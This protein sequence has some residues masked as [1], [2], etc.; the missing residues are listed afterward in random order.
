MEEVI[1]PDRLDGYQLKFKV[2]SPLKHIR[3][4]LDSDHKAYLP[5]ITHP[6][7]K[8]LDI[9]SIGFMNSGATRDV[10]EAINN[11]KNIDHLLI[12]LTNKELE[13]LA[14]EGPFDC[15]E[16]N[17]KGEGEKLAV[18]DLEKLYL[19][20]LTVHIRKYEELEV[21]INHFSTSPSPFTGLKSFHLVR[22]RVDYKSKKAG[23]GNAARVGTLM[24][25]LEKAGITF[26]KTEV[27]DEDW[28]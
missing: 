5:L 1:L 19:K 24:V 7:L 20:N 10:G 25:E 13:Q 3:F 21:F 18:K 17:M 14:L 16:L 15:L 6:T 4:A 27:L 28:E 2:I 9:D 26:S 11:A 12:T 8:K 23:D 22:H